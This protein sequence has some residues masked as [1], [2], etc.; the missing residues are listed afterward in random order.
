MSSCS[1]VLVIRQLARKALQNVVVALKPLSSDF[2]GA[3]SVAQ[4]T[5]GFLQV[6]AVAKT[7]LAG[8]WPEFHKAVHEIF[9][10]DVPKT[11]FTYAW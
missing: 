3:H 6:L 4:G 5:V 10:F 8:K 2:A 7:A 1:H 9:S 11:E